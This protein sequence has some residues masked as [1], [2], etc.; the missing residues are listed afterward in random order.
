MN[1]STRTPQP[2]RPRTSIELIDSIVGC[3]QRTRRTIS[4]ISTVTNAVTVVVLVA[5]AVGTTTAWLI[6]LVLAGLALRGRVMAARTARLIAG[7]R[8]V[9]EEDT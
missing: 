6:P 9:A 1:H 5:A 3:D 8:V 7:R 4:M 2:R